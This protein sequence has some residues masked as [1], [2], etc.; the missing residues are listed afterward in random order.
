[1]TITRAQFMEAPSKYI[2]LPE[3]VEVQND[4]GSTLMFIGVGKRKFG[5]LDYLKKWRFDFVL[6]LQCALLRVTRPFRAQEKLDTS[7]LE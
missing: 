2:G 1:M 4:D 3:G 7:W 6:W 5:L